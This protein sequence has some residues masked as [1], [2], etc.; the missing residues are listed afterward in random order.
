MK[1]QLALT[2]AISFVF[3]LQSLGQN[4]NM[5]N[6]N[7]TTCGG[8][9]YDNGGL[10]LYSSNQNL[11]QTFTPGT[12]GSAIKVSFTSFQ[13]SAATD[14]L[15]IYDGPNTTSNLIGCY[16]GLNILNGLS[17]KSTHPS[18]SL[19]FTFISN[20]FTNL[21]G[22]VATVS[23][24]FA[25]QSFSANADSTIP[26]GDTNNEIK[27]CIG[28]TVNMFGDATYPNSGNFY[29]QSNA[30]STFTWKTGDGF[31]IPGQNA[32]HTFTTAGVFDL[33]LVVEDTL[34]CESITKGKRVVVS[35]QPSFKSIE[36]IPNDSICLGDT[37]SIMIPDSG[38]FEPFN[39]PALS[40]AGVTAI[41]DIL[42]T[43]FTSTIPV[44][45]FAPTATFGA[46]Y[47][48]GIYLNI[49]HSWLGD[50]EITI[51]CPNGQRATLKENPGGGGSFLGEP[52]DNTVAGN[53][54]NGYT[55]EFTNFSPTYGTMNN[56]SGNYNQTYVDNNGVTVTNDYLP[57]GT[58]T[59]FQ[60]LNTQLAGCPLNGNWTIT[61]TDHLGADDGY[62]FFWGLNFDTL[63]RPPL[64]V[65]NAITASKVSSSWTSL[66]RIIG[67]TTDT[68]VQVSP[69]SSGTHSYTYQ[70][71]D[72]FGCTHD[73]TLDIFVKP[74]PK[75]NAGVD[76]TTC[77]LNQT[78]TPIPTPGATV[79]SWNY[80]T[81]PISHTSTFDDSS[82]YSPNATVSDFGV[83]SYV[84]QERLDGC[85]T[86]PDTVNISYV[87]VQNTINI[88][89][90]KDSVCIPESVV[91][92]NNSDMTFFDSIYWEFGDG[93]ISNSQGSASHIYNNYTCFDVKVTLVNALGCSVDSIFPD[94]ICGFP[95]T[96]ADFTYDPA[97]SIIPNTLINFTNQ[98]SGA[99]TFLWDFSGLGNSTN[100]DDFFIFPKT[101]GGIYPVTLFVNNEGGCTDQIT[102]NVTIKNPL[103]YWAPNSF[104]PDDDGLNDKFRV[105]FNN[106]SVEEYEI[107]IFNRWG[108]L[109]YNSQEIDFEWDGTHNGEEVPNGVYVWRIIGKEK[110]STESFEKI[111][112]VTLT[113]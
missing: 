26:L 12:A 50:L 78:L 64:A 38:L 70:I 31:T 7:I 104:T 23:C 45:I 32:T 14:V 98:S 65:S 73:T 40:V 41:P 57:A 6:G 42:L 48:K 90:D 35:T 99:S 37:T 11:T 24:E 29:N 82:I 63:I 46:G 53:I 43:P 22:W 1:K 58:Y 80:F 17:F 61:V 56:E 105:V 95:T 97:E 92:T 107:Y 86:Y 110:L 52:I 3:F 68:I 100:Q 18:G 94:M 67:S 30:T 88:S 106:N 25:C 36:F 103:S 113:R 108:E 102:K 54:G 51:T 72:D 34:G 83:Y 27:V 47:L 28:T 39:P 19:T 20:G 93:A 71:V 74:K 111:G 96:V 69:T 62:I 8:T 33:S 75:S 9:F 21:N 60:N 87:Q 44:S 77:L 109:L 66:S 16:S 91:F 76:F 84:L 13:T 112:H 55:Y 85:L 49:E 59:P 4:Y 15:C 89:A 2:L 101:D 10:G 5:S 79:D 81:N